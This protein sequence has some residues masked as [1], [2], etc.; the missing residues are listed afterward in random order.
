MSSAHAQSKRWPGVEGG[1][2]GEE[3]STEGQPEV[4]GENLEK[5]G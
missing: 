3:G 1:L 5:A 2:E 4:R